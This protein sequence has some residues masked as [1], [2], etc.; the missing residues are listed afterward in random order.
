MS[1]NN[2][3]KVESHSPQKSSFKD[4]VFEKTSNA[5]KIGHPVIADASIGIA[6]IPKINEEQP[7]KKKARTQVQKCVVCKKIGDDIRNRACDIHREEI[8]LKQNLQR[9]TSYKNTLGLGVDRLPFKVRYN[10]QYNKTSSY[11]LDIM[12]PASRVQGE[13]IGLTYVNKGAYYSLKNHGVAYVKKFNPFQT[14]N[15]HSSKEW[16]LY[17]IGGTV[18]C[19][20][21]LL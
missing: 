7:V 11:L 20:L 14:H 8:K 1:G 5:L 4:P 10:V 6:S 19:L 16:L 3:K 21:I 12:M 9:S 17:L 18:S 15:I 13:F 2:V